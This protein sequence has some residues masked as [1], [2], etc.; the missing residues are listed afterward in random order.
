MLTSAFFHWTLLSFTWDC[1]VLLGAP[2]VSTDNPKKVELLSEILATVD[3]N[4]VNK[5]IG[6]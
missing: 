3:Y 2:F 6:R 1:E 5:T 4:K